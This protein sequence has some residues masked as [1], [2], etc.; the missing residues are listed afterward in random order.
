MAII[1]SFFM[2]NAYFALSA[3]CL[4]LGQT[5]ASLDVLDL[6]VPR[7]GVEFVLLEFFVPTDPDTSFVFVSG[8]VKAAP[9]SFRL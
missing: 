5:H 3:N 6:D 8:L 7:R 4:S 9:K 2:H 1:V